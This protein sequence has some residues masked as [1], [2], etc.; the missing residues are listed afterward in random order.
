MEGE[1]LALSVNG[2]TVEHSVDNVQIKI[3]WGYGKREGTV[4]VTV[5][6]VLSKTFL[7]KD[8]PYF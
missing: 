8:E 5:K 1:T 6:M 7:N 4:S 2:E 3:K